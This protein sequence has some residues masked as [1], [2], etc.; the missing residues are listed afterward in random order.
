MGV[1]ITFTLVGCTGE[2]FQ[3]QFS[4]GVSGAGMGGRKLQAGS[5]LP[6]LLSSRDSRTALALSTK[7]FLHS[8]SP[9]ELRASYAR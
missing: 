6:T 9:L 4:T 8:V 1:D 5:V 2:L 7:T 3:D